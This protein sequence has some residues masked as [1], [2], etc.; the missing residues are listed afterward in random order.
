MSEHDKEVAGG[1][2]PPSELEAS[3]DRVS[4]RYAEEFYRELARKPFDRELLD[5]F[6]DWARGRGRVCEIGCGPGQVARYLKD[7]AVDVYGVD[8]SSGQIECAR[9]LNPDITFERGDLLALDAAAASLAGVITLG[10]IHLT[11]VRFRA[12]VRS[13]R[14]QGLNQSGLERGSA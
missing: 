11:K 13:S 7:R 10:I 5:E 14:R 9:R 2:R 1:R 3:Y 8:L 12:T 6:A 4:A